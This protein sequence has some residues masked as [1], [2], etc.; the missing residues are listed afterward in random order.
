MKRSAE[1]AAS[2]INDLVNAFGGTDQFMYAIA[3]YGMP[4]AEAARVRARLEEID[5][6]ATDRKNFWRMVKAGVVPRD[7]AER[8]AKFFAAGIVGENPQ[9][10]GL[11]SRPLS[12][13]Y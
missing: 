2:Y 5:P 10:F 7:G 3:C 13:L 4:L 6:E 9:A 8:V 11:S 1:I 12:S